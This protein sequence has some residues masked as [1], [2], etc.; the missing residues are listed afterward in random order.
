MPA[1]PTKSRLANQAWEALL[2]AH[3]VLI[4]ELNSPDVWDGTSMREYDVLYTLSKCDGPL[5]LS[6]LHR[7]VLLSQPALSR[8]VERLVEQG[9][10][11]RTRDPQDGRS[12]RLALTAAGVER[13]RVIG[14]RHAVGVARTV[15]AMLDEAEL[16]QLEALCRKLAQRA[17]LPPTMINRTINSNSHETTPAD[18]GTDDE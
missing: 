18:T 3:A 1:T 13:Q 8:L 12:V 9:L 14:G 11:R 6:E 15:G 5:R 17:D 7:N 10:V 2:T 4:K 16:R